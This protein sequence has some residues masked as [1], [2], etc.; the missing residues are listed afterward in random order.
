M[1][2]YVLI[3]FQLTVNVYVADQFDLLCM[4]HHRFDTFSGCE[5]CNQNRPN[6]GQYGEGMAFVNFYAKFRYEVLET[7]IEDVWSELA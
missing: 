1:I 2:V 5:L 3:H 7:Y 4:Q 6:I